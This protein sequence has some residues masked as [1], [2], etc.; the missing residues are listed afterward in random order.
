[1]ELFPA[2]DLKDGQCVRLTQGDFNAVTVYDSDPLSM[3]KKFA[4]AGARWLHIV[5]LDGARDGQSRQLDL[6]ARIVEKTPLKV[7]TGGGIR[8]TSTIEQLIASGAARI[9][10]GSLAVKNRMPGRRLGSAYFRSGSHCRSPSMCGW[11]I[12]SEARGAYAWLAN[13]QPIVVMGIAGSVQLFGLAN[14][15]L[16]RCRPRRYVER[17]E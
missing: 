3:A 10:I 7:Q 16:H 14:T 6:I 8:E 9:V 13:R 2:I 1:M 4:D 17:C 11:T 15:A 12:R 5:D